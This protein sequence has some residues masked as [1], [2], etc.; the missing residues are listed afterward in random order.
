[1]FGF[2]KG[3]SH[4]PKSQMPFEGRPLYFLAVGASLVKRLRDD[5]R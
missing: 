2:K 1:M 5:N 3:N 4:S